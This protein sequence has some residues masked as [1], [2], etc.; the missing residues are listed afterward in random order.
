MGHPFK[1]PLQMGHT[2]ALEAVFVLR[3]SSISSGMQ[4]HYWESRAI[5]P[6]IQVE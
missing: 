1:I 3:S 4:L 2:E 6:F 5:S